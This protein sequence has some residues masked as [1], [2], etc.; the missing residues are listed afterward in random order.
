M[1]KRSKLILAPR[2]SSVQFI[3]VCPIMH[4]MVGLPGSLYFTGMG[5]VNKSLMLDARKTFLGTF[6]FLFFLKILHMKGL[7][8]WHQ[9]GAH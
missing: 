5:P 9:E 7:V 1:K 4:E 3:V 6:V 8:V 2:Y